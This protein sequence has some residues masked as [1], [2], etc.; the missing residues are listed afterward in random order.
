VRFKTDENLPIEAATLLRQ[1][2]HDA[3][4]VSDQSLAGDL[5]L[6]HCTLATK[7]SP[8]LSPKFPAIP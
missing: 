3:L 5:R 2:G 4:T 8:R 6:R 1:H 7:I